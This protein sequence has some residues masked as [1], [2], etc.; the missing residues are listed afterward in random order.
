MGEGLIDESKWPPKARK[1]LRAARSMLACA[2]ATMK[3]LRAIRRVKEELPEGLTRD[4]ALALLKATYEQQVMYIMTP[5]PF[6]TGGTPVGIFRREEG[7][8]A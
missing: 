8:K 7:E 6:L 1:S 2:E 5:R 3:Y 4:V